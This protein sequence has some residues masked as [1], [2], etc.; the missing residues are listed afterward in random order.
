MYVC[1]Y[2]ILGIQSKPIFKNISADTFFSLITSITN[3]HINK[4][5][6]K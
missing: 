1:M 3:L 2:L 4:Y 6:V 5:K